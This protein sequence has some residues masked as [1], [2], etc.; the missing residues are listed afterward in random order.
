[1][2]PPSGGLARPRGDV[3]RGGDVGAT[4]IYI[5]T[6]PREAA[7][8]CPGALPIPFVTAGVYI[9]VCGIL[10]E[11]TFLILKNFCSKNGKVLQK[12]EK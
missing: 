2:Q 10:R 4:H 7:R 5:Y 8:P 3:D 12:T 11:A 6:S 9:Y 1:M